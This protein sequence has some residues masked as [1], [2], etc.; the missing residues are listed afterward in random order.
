MIKKVLAVVLIF[1]ILLM[2]MTVHAKT[3][4]K[5]TTPKKTSLYDKK[6]GEEVATVK[7]NTKLKIVRENIHWAKVEYKDSKY[8]VETKWLHTQKCVKKLTGSK[9]RRKGVVHWKNKKYTWYSQR[10][11]PGYGLKIPGRHVD[12]QGFVCDKNDYIV[13]G[14]NTRNRGK[15]IPT[16]FGKF[17]KVYDAGYVGTYWFDC[18]TNF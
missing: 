8:W 1:S 17:G 12:K 13:L 15:I 3:T 6:K 10:I 18:Y 9:F 16:P 7:R 4:Y 11:L 14:S 2:P 5:Y